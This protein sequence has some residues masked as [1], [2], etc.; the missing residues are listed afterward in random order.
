MRLIVCAAEFVCR[1]PNVRWPVSA[2]RSADS[3]VSRSRISPISTT[4]GSW[5]SALLSALANE[6]VSAC[7]SRWLTMQPCGVWRNSTGS[8]I[9]MMCS[10][11]SR[12]ILSIIAASVVDLPDPVG[13]VT[14]TSPRGL[15]QI[16]STTGGKAELLEAED[17]VGNLPVDRG[18]RAALVEDVSAEPGESLDSEREVELEVLLEP[19][20]LGVGEH[21]V[22]ELL[23]LG[24]GQRQGSR[25][26]ELAVDPD[27]RRRSWS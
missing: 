13:P 25:A 1:V 18:H 27:L 26:A 23:G 22:G 6:C 24:R 21:R 5:R 8:S 4:S 14:R 10:C 3:I 11:R 12:L 2:I 16:S 15:L 19:V 17:L 20:L 9:V 7:S